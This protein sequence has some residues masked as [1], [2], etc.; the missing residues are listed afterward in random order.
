MVSNSCE[1]RVWR[2]LEIDDKAYVVCFTKEN[3]SWKVILTDLIEIWTENLT[4]KIIL[5][6]FE[7]SNRLVDFSK[8]SNW[9]QLVMDMLNDIPKHVVETSISQIKLQKDWHFGK[10]KFS[11]D[12]VKGTPQ[13]FWEYVM[14]PF[15][16]SSMEIVHQHGI[17]LD[18]V[19]K[20]DE[21]IA[22]YKAG[23]AVLLRKYIATEPFSKELFQ[24][25]VPVA[26]NFTKIF[27]SMFNSSNITT[28]SRTQVKIEPEVSLNDAS[29]DIPR[30]NG[31]ETASSSKDESVQKTKQDKSSKDEKSE[32]NK[33]ETNSTTGG[34]S[35]LKLSSSSYSIQKSLK[36]KK[37]TLSDLIR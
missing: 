10:L 12:L 25:A 17:L 13:Q 33:C 29:D 15:C 5:C 35:I 36:K 20:K 11:L 22:E 9:K 34:S 6:K 7:T 16:L 27:Q 32:E 26:T 3:E 21:E 23:G 31:S 2:S 28:L 19:K 14:K 1:Q 4:Y 37:K 18:L 30:I 8:V 24:V